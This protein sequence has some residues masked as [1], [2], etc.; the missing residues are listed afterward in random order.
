MLSRRGFNQRMIQ[1]ITGLGSLE[2]LL[3]FWD[4]LSHQNRVWTQGHEKWLEGQ[5]TDDDTHL[6]EMRQCQLLVTGLMYG[7]TFQGLWTVGLSLLELTH[8]HIF[9]MY[10][11]HSCPTTSALGPLYF[12]LQSLFSMRYPHMAFPTTAI[13][14]PLNSLSSFLPQTL[15]FQL[16]SLHVWQITQFP[17]PISCSSL[18]QIWNMLHYTDWLP[19]LWRHLSNSALPFLQASSGAQPSIP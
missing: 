6:E 3:L 16:V 2:A 18:N 7:T 15:M 9:T 1:Q 12:P 14:M 5:T 11:Y 13:L 17:P 10:I 8:I 4:L 19:S